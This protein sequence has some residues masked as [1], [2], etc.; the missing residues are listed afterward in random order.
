[1]IKSL[2]VEFRFG[3]RSLKD[4]PD[5]GAN[6][7][8]VAMNRL[9]KDYW[10]VL[11]KTDIKLSLSVNAFD[12]GGCPLEPQ[13]K[14][15]LYQR[16][17]KVLVF[18]PT[19]IWLDH[20]RFDGHWE[21]IK[22]KRIPG[23]H[24]EC[25]RCRGQ[26]R[27]KTLADIAR[28]VKKGI[29]KNVGLGYFAVPFRDVEVPELVSGLGQDH[30]RLAEFFDLVSPMLYHRMIGK[31]IKYIHDYVVWLKNKTQKPTLPIIQVK[32]MPDELPDKLSEEEIVSAFKEAAKAPSVGVAFFCWDHAIEKGKTQIIKKLFK[33]E[34]GAFL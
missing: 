11:S 30:R 9:N 33:A 20:F 31:P 2:F 7:L 14:A 13:A 19:E 22:G 6:H 25:Q 26:D 24:Q 16:I 29:P 28:E 34:F 1:M 27:V 23:I 3:E 8:I 4:L 15:K 17:K 32:D 21:A 12:H 18:K 5:S 10:Q